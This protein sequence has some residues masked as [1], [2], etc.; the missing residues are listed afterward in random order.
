MRFCLTV[1]GVVLV[2]LGAM[3]ASSSP[4]YVHA[5]TKKAKK[6]KVPKHR[7]VQQ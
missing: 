6:H 4:V 3:P 2:T 1:L 7:V 5:R